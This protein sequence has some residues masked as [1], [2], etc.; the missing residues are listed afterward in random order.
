[1]E[2]GI[3]CIVCTYISSDLI[4][5]NF[6]AMEAAQCYM[7]RRCKWFILYLT[8][9]SLEHVCLGINKMWRVNHV[10]NNLTF[11]LS[12]CYSMRIEC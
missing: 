3:Y 9:F 4:T 1:M 6:T 12:F 10:D 7:S 5:R 8:Q 2:L 11:R